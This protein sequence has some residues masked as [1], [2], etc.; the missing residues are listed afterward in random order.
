M[1]FQNGFQWGAA[2]ASYQIEGSA[3][4][5]GG[6]E[7]V[8]DMFCLREGKTSEGDSGEIACD[9]YNRYAEVGS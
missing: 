3:R 7:S 6:G 4:R 9:H 5:A 1:A 8:W 2:T